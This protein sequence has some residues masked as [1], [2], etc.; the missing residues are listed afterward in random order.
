[1]TTRSRSEIAAQ[2]IL[3]EC[4][5]TEPLQLTLE[6]ILNSKNLLIKEEE[7]E[8]ADG[9]IVMNENGGIVTINS[10][11]T[12]PAKKLFVMAH[13]LGHFELHRS[14]SKLF[15]DDDDTLN[16]WYEKNLSSEETEANEFAAELLMPSDV[17][18]NECKGK[19]FNPAIIEHLADRFQVSK[20]A[21]ILRFVKQGNHPVCVVYCKANRMKWWKKSD[22]FR[23]FL[24]FGSNQEP[25][26][27]SVAR[28]LFTTSNRY[29]GDEQQQTI[30]KSTWFE[31][32]RDERDTTFYE[33][34]L[35][36]RS[37][38]YTLSILWE[39]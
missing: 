33:F 24:N 1:M 9:R 26:A 8:G 6:V 35:Y 36:A 2:R 10:G 3:D 20:T 21:A 13:E 17:F 22:D 31:L 38:N 18:Y 37:Y 34:C 39:D 23:Y 28:E 27:N 12:V 25:P 11:I 29:Y 7:I 5:V 14:K 16:R 15:S 30:W 4:G 32:R 19:K